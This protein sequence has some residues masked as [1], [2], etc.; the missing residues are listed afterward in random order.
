MRFTEIKILT[1]NN[2]TIR[3]LSLDKTLQPFGKKHIYMQVGDL[4][5]AVWK[6]SNFSCRYK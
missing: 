2:Q 5:L 3:R 4:N 6:K 1:S